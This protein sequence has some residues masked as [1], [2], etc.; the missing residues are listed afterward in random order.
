M[1]RQMHSLELLYGCLV[2]IGLEALNGER[3]YKKK[4]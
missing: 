2:P 4:G 1:L 3:L